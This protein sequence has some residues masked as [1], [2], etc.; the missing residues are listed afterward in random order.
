MIK[1]KVGDC[2]SWNSEAGRVRGKIKRIHRKPFNLSGKDGTKY[3]RHASKEDVVYEI[4][5]NK[6]DHLAYHYGRTL[7]KVKC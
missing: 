3:K 4:K 6:S 2:V 5:S 7:R 1:Y